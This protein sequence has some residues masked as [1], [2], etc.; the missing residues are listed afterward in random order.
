MPRT[1]NEVVSGKSK[2]ISAQQRLTLDHVNALIQ[3]MIAATL[4]T[5]TSKCTC[6]VCETIRKNTG[7]IRALMNVG[8]R[9]KHI[10]TVD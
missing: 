3:T 8:S 7:H 5:A 4:D 10:E 2:S 9:I 6:S 1:E